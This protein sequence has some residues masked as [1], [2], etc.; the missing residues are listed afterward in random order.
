M[1]ILT[2]LR[3]QRKKKTFNIAQGKL[4]KLFNIAL[5]HC[6]ICLDKV[7]LKYFQEIQLW[8]KYLAEQNSTV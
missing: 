6:V 8:K 2:S 3:I 1:H 7:W 5:S 4:P